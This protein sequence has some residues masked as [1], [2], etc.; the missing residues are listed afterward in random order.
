[1]KYDERAC[2][3]NMD[4]GC[5]EL[6]LRDGRM[7]S[8]DC[9][10]VEDELDVTMAQ[11]TELDYLIYN[12]PLAL[13]RPDSKRRAGRIFEKYGWEPWVR[14]LREMPFQKQL[15]RHFLFFAIRHLLSPKLLP[16]GTELLRHIR[17]GHRTGDIH[18]PSGFGGFIEP[19]FILHGLQRVL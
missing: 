4:T 5:V 14:R 16:D 12:D 19:A 6:L 11:R 15:E 10:G 1:M 17:I 9:T 2:K 7:I 3:F 18:C 13:C 8:I